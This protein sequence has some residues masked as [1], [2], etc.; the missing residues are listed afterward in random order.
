MTNP[1]H[2]TDPVG[3][4]FRGEAERWAAL[5]DEALRAAAD[6]DPLGFVADHLPRHERREGSVAVLLDCGPAGPR[7]VHVVSD[8]PLRPSPDACRAVLDRVA[9]LALDRPAGIRARIGVIHHRRG[10]PEVHDL[11]RRWAEALRDVAAD[12]GL[13]VLGV[14]ARIEDGALV[15]VADAA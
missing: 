15:R 2:H 13:A 1:S 10:G 6:Q 4:A 3:R 7:S 9:E 5:H 12:A 14:A 11:D 8:A